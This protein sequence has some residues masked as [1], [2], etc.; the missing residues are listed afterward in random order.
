VVGEDRGIELEPDAHDRVEELEQQHRDEDAAEADFDEERPEAA[1]EHFREVFT[2][3]SAVFRRETVELDDLTAGLS[4]D[5]RVAIEALQEVVAGRD[6]QSQGLVYAERRLALLNDALAVLQPALAQALAPDLVA[7]RDEYDALV[8]GVH[9]LR[10]KLENL[11]SAQEEMFEQDRTKDEEAGKPEPPDDEDKPDDEG[12][13][14]AE[15]GEQPSTLYGEP[16]EDAAEE[17]P[18]KS[19]VWEPDAG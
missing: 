2:A 5:E 4:P 8:E 18:K 15:D 7:F 19:T 13:G 6:P 1:A 12:E 9:D 10:E 14:E 3:V 11:D 16:G 17:P